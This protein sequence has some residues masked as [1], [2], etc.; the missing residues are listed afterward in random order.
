MYFVRPAE[1]E[2]VDALIHHARQG[3]HSLPHDADAMA[4]LVQHSMASFDAAVKF[5]GDEAYLFVLASSD[6]DRVHGAAMLS[7]RAGAAGTFFAFRNEVIHQVSRDLGISHSVHVLELSSDLTAHS[8][9]SGFWVCNPEQAGDGADLLSRARLLF[10]AAEPHRIGE[11][12]FASPPGFT[13]EDGVSPFWEA[14]GRKFFKIGF[15]DAERAVQ[16][17]R[18]RALIVELM[19]HYPIYVPLL[20]GDAQAAMGQVHPQGELAYR[21]LAGEGFGTDQFIDIF[22]GGPIL[23]ASRQALRSFSQST[24]RLAQC[25]GAPPGADATRY[26]ISNG[27]TTGFRAIVAECPPI[28]HT[29]S[30][31]LT[32]AMLRTLEVA[33]GDLVLCTKL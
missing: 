8:Q 13:G 18:N 21:I 31:D 32:D 16:G 5:P 17:T 20:P 10:A 2:D 24:T 14:L 25:A 7:A 3:V 19:P 1:P 11:S 33:P 4:K 6:D 22:D 26:L 15:L 12:I 29:R 23:Q 9:L 30:V 28:D 27:R